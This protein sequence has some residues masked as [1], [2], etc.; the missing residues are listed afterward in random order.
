M[1][2]LH[3]ATT[4]L[5]LFTIG[6]GH[7]GHGSE[8]IEYGSPTLVVSPSTAIADGKTPVTLTV[9]LSPAQIAAGKATGRRV[10]VTSSIGGDAIA[11]GYTNS[12]GVFTTSLASSVVGMRTLT[13][14]VDG[15][16]TSQQVNLVAATTCQGTPLFA[17]GVPLRE[18]GLFPTSITRG[19]FNKD[20]K[21]DL[22]VVNE[23]EDPRDGLVT[24]LIGNGNGTFQPNVE[25]AATCPPRR[26]RI[27]NFAHGQASSRRAI[28]IM[29]AFS[30]LSPGTLLFSRAMGKQ[31]C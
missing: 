6:C 18:I 3:I 11:S 31:A 9:T 5:L 25:Y 8:G 17:S 21:L 12:H 13:A 22:A 28:S 7:G 16:E 26:R 15:A 2:I 19:D 4:C 1:R 10:I 24:V 29:T 20:G 14:K 27:A 30:I 23:P